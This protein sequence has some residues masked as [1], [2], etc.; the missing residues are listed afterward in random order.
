MGVIPV[1][2][3]LELFTKICDILDNV[4]SKQVGKQFM[5]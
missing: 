3:V 2:E 1:Q 4:I 5:F